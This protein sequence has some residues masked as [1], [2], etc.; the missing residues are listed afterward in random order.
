[1]SLR[2]P[3]LP[4]DA[5]AIGEVSVRRWIEEDAEALNLAVLESLE[6]LRP[7]MEWAAEP[8]LSP[9]ARRR[10]IRQMH[11]R[12]AAGGDCNYVIRVGERVAGSCGL[13]RRLG[14][15]G[16]EIGYWLHPDFTGRGVATTAAELL[17]SA[18]FTVPDI[19]FV[20]IHH[21]QA[22]VR[23]RRIPERLG[24]TLVASV[25][26]EPTAPGELG[27]ECRWRVTRDEWVARRAA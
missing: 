14:P 19:E 2:P 15:G 13:H 11:V 27:V 17:T 20:E 25:P 8:P 9:R 7:W 23:S 24:Y 26:D 3:I 10:Q 1:M 22:N 6:H 5:G 12:W 21:D 16:L 4:E 18:A